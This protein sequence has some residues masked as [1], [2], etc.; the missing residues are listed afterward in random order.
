[1]LA[2]QELEWVVV[3]DKC[4][5]VTWVKEPSQF[6]LLL[7]YRKP[8]TLWQTRPPRQPRKQSTT[9]KSN[10]TNSLQTQK[11]AENINYSY[12]NDAMPDPRPI[13]L[14]SNQIW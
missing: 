11:R 7:K 14:R 6:N 8:S 4:N 3:F 13:G 2:S 10:K 1:M 9:N 12:Q 5:S